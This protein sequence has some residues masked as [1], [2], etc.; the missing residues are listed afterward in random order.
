[1]PAPVSPPPAHS[2]SLT[3]RHG[4]RLHWR[5]AGAAGATCQRPARPA[6]HNGLC[7]A[8]A[9]HQLL[10]RRNVMSRETK[11]ARTAMTRLH[12]RKRDFFLINALGSL[13]FK[14]FALCELF[15]W[16]VGSVLHGCRCCALIQQ[17][18]GMP[19]D[20]VG[21]PTRIPP[22]LQPMR[23]CVELCL[24]RCAPRGQTRRGDCD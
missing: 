3:S 17:C 20:N 22:P 21:H 14:V 23:S 18:T 4:P 10:T 8:A 5:A 24:D 16:H 11:S 6:R 15:L 9:D 19:R 2:W 7:L 1:M 13:S 12:F